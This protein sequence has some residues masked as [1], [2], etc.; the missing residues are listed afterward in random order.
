MNLDINTNSS[1]GILF[2]LI[3]SLVLLANPVCADDN[4][5][6]PFSINQT[7]GSSP[8]NNSLYPDHSGN[9]ETIISDT[10]NV[11][12]H[13]NDVNGIFNA[14]NGFQTD[15]SGKENQPGK[16]NQSGN[17][18]TTGTLDEYTDKYTIR[19]FS[20]IY[21]LL[22]L[23]ISAWVVLLAH[24]AE[25]ESSERYTYKK[26]PFLTAFLILAYMLQGLYLFFITITMTSGVGLEDIGGT[27]PLEN[28]FISWI[29]LS[30]SLGCIYMAYSIIEKRNGIFVW[31]LTMIL[32]VLL[33]SATL[34]I[35]RP[36]SEV[37][38]YMTVA[39]G[40]IALLINGSY[41]AMI[42]RYPAFNPND[43][44]I[45]GT[46]DRRYS[47]YFSDKNLMK[48]Q[49][50]KLSSFPDIL[51]ERYMQ[52]EF[53]GRGGMAKVFKVKRRRDGKIVALKIPIYLDEKTG[54][55]LFREMNIWKNLDHKNIVHVFDL[56]ILPV[57]FVEMEYFRD[58]LAGLKKPADERESAAIISGIAEGLSYAHERGIV[59]RDIK[60]Q[61]ILLTEDNIPKIADWG[62]GKL[63]MENTETGTMAFSLHYAAPEQVLPK[64]FGRCDRR[65]DIFQL[66][67][68]CYE[69]LTGE[70]PFSGDGIG[71]FTTA[72]ISDE[73]K[74]PS[75]YSPEL[76]KY[77][78]FILKGLEKYPDNRYSSV[79]EFISALKKC[80]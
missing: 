76:Q 23:F 80:R 65:T 39:T 6:F 42:K 11:I 47:E 75:Y 50:T 14:D 27:G 28:F 38:I 54:I 22:I 1:K 12:S 62:L 74:P 16:E 37:Q 44:V 59:H 4:E 10:N 45:T 53:I 77:D 13:S 15:Y 17:L 25:K 49:N 19:F 20:N 61:N 60:P 18:S 66:S 69:L 34:F 57:P 33:L 55:N 78:D 70:L 8:A 2:L 67:V 40:I 41:F 52:D 43:T 5:I 24:I 32:T 46:S 58:S 3:I 71:E 30:L 79:E 21:F 9:D 68:I 7:P 48:D 35:I 36:D 56:N 29:S 64:R 72:I 31:C 63:V 51:K 26:K 73:P